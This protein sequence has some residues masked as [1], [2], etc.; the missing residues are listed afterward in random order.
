MEEI[1][2][3]FD[4]AKELFPINRSITGDGVRKT[5]EIIRE[6]LPGLKTIEVTTGEKCFDWT[7]P[8]EWN[9]KGAWVKNSNGEKII[10]FTN[11]NLHLM[12]YSI[13]IN[14][15]MSL[16]ELSSHLFYI[17]EQPDA[18][19][20]VT[21]YYSE[22]WGF[23]LTF[24]QFRK[25][26]DDV[27]HVCIDSSLENGSLTYG[28]LYLP[29]T[30]TEEILLSTN[31]C[32]PSM[33]NNEL[34]GIVVTTYLA[35]HLQKVTDRRY[36]YRILFLPETIGSICYLSKNSEELKRNV[37]AGFVIVC[38]GDNNN[39]SF[40]PSRNG[41][42]LADKV[43]RFVLA[44]VDNVKYYTFLDR[45]SDERQFCS[46]LIDLP[47]ASVMRSKYGEYPEYH[48]SLDNLDFISKEG[49]IGA[50]NIYK[51]IFY[52]LE[53]NYYP[54]A[55]VP[56]EPN[57]GSR[58]LYPQLSTKTTFDEV[59]SIINLLAY[60]D[61]VHSMIDISKNIGRSISDL[62]AIADKLNDKKLISKLWH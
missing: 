28:E 24:N 43:A 3:I 7:V 44:E 37:K 62:I 48:T 12:G 40:L 17:E 32:H 59:Y 39:Y 21:S 23:C 49:L 6:K 27:Y 29:G 53:N 55:E 34:S 22:N 45:G 19:P 9:V 13:P 5:L 26:K 15:A 58:G 35:A 57:L 14:Q 50:Y 61:G 33:G 25:L 46:P 10:D 18:I 42:T 52:C 1:E 4:F 47:V 2:D 20:Y 54:K 51:H 8:K 11:S 30:S 60:A 36:S 56:C 31:I 41:N 16:E 38:V